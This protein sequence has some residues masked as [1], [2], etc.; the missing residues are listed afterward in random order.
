MQMLYIWPLFAFF[1]APLLLPS[2][3]SLLGQLFQTVLSVVKGPKDGETS[4]PSVNLG[5]Q[6]DVKERNQ[7]KQNRNGSAPTTSASFALASTEF[8][9]QKASSPIFFLGGIILSLAIIK[10]N[11]IVHPFTLADNRHYMFYIFRY[12][13]LRSTKVRFSLLGAYALSAWLVWNRLAGC[14]PAAA[15]S[16]AVASSNRSEKQGTPVPF[17]STPFPSAEM[18]DGKG[19]SETP[20]STRNAQGQGSIL[21]LDNPSSVSTTPPQTST[22]L[23][24]LLT[25]SLSLI[26]APLVEP[27]YFILPWV[28]WRLLVPAWRAPEQLPHHH[29]TDRFVGGLLRRLGGRKFDLTVVLETVWFLIV[30]VATMYVFLRW[31]YVWKGEDGAVLDGGRVQRF[32]W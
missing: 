8:L 28:F 11:T 13:I 25:T 19:H 6:G 24:W 27:R 15:A 4:R 16:S 31:P 2:A 21:T 1:S 18:L 20:P 12:T 17:I 32:M 30:N 9:C 10:Y 7:P 22:A 29:I 5:T 14:P 26:T 23:L 3:V